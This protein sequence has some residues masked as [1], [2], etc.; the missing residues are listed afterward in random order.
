MTAAVSFSVLAGCGNGDQPASGNG[1]P[2]DE[3]PLFCN[4]WLNP[5]SLLQYA[6]FPNTGKQGIIGG[7]L[8]YGPVR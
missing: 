1:D 6:D 5:F 3:I 2:D 8:R 7:E 4:S